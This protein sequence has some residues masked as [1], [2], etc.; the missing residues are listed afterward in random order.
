MSRPHLWMLKPEGIS[1]K[2]FGIKSTNMEKLLW[3]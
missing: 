2:F 1:V 3:L